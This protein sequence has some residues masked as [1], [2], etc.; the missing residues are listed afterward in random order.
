MM[1]VAATLEVS[2]DALIRRG[3]QSSGL[4][5]VALGFCV[6]GAYGVVVNL[7]GL[8][9]SRLF[10]SYVGWFALVSVLAGKFVFRDRLPLTTWIGLGIVLAGSLVI[11][12]G[13]RAS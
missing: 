1:L 4:A 3:L 8:D 11:Q 2:G 6:L 10:G 7:V 13:P 9:F 12:F 5:L